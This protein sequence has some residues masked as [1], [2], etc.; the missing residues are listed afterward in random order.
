MYAAAILKDMTQRSRVYQCGQTLRNYLRAADKQPFDNWIQAVVQNCALM[1]YLD[2][3][4]FASQNE[5]LRNVMPLSGA[6]RCE[7]QIYCREL[8]ARKTK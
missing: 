2:D 4:T 5:A 7:N 8:R 6:C 3:S 1:S